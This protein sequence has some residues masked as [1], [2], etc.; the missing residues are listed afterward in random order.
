M[1]TVYKLPVVAEPKVEY[2]A[3]AKMGFATHTFSDPERAKTFIKERPDRML[4]L[5]KRTTTEEEIPL[6]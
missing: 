2:I 5:V 3:K 6:E 1:A 4:T